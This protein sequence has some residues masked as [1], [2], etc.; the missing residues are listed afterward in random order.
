MKPINNIFLLVLVFILTSCGVS[1]SLKD[2]PNLSQFNSKIDISRTKI[3]DSTF[4]IG[5]NQLRK[6]Q[7]GMYELYV[8]GDALERGL[9]TG[10][11]TKELY[12]K[13]EK[14]FFSKI[15]EI[16]PSKT[17]QYLLRKFLAWFN[18]KIYLHIPNEYKAE[19]YGISKFAGNDY[20]YIADDYHRN[21][22]LHGAH[23]IGHALKDLALVG[24]SSFC[25]KQNYFI[26]KSEEG[27]PFYVGYL[28]WNDWC[29]LRNERPRL[30]RYD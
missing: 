27:T 13:Q 5:A 2:V 24:C 23:D 6:N 11:L 20:D 1:K 8:K 30:N 12:Q 18:R 16:I 29:S 22:Y 26:C 28:G 21:L 15:E 25:Q 10:S 9:L 4:V 17:K 3:N 7:Q 14:I 19:I